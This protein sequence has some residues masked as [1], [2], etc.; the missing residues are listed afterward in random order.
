MT[1]QKPKS[2]KHFS[3][4]SKTEVGTV[5]KVC[6]L[7]QPCHWTFPWIISENKDC[8]LL[9]SP[10]KSLKIRK[11]Y[12]TKDIEKHFHKEQRQVGII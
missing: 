12:E 7:Q 11:M 3:T 4:T 8:S 2:P 9:S 1:E 5:K 10:F 6:V